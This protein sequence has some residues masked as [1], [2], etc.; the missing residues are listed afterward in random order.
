[1]SIEIKKLKNSKAIVLVT[2]KFNVLHPGHL[3]LLKFAKECGS[4]LI[5]AVESDLLAGKSAHVSEKLRLEGVQSNTFVNEAFIYHD[6][7]IDVIKKL[8]PDIVVKGK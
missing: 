1:M 6:S 7:V 8:H 3:R 4:R 5:V 2:G